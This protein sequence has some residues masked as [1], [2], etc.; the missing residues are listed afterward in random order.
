VREKHPYKQTLKSRY[1][2]LEMVKPADTSLQKPAASNIL[3]CS[4]WRTSSAE[5]FEGGDRRLNSNQARDPPSSMTLYP[6][7]PNINPHPN[8]VAAKTTRSSQRLHFH[9]LE[10]R[11][12]KYLSRSPLPLMNLT[13]PPKSYRI[14]KLLSLTTSIQIVES[15][16]RRPPCST[17]H[18]SS[19]SLPGAPCERDHLAFECMNQSIEHRWVA[20]I[21]H[22]PSQS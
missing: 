1:Q 19:T 3:V 11:N 20:C 8:R 7:R 22:Q 13:H 15:C 4:A 14:L 17:R 21:N 10:S 6:M 9:P 18:G 5:R 16:N 2:R 12:Y